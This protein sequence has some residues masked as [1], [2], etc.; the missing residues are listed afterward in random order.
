[1]PKEF[2]AVRSADLEPNTDLDSAPV[3][4]PGRAAPGGDGSEGVA[5]REPSAVAAGHWEKGG[6][7]RYA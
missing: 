7:G 5:A 3:M 4:A 2:V 1:M 6:A